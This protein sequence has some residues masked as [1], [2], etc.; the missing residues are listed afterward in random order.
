MPGPLAGLTVIEIASIGPEHFCAMMLADMGTT[1]VRVDRRDQVGRPAHASDVINRDRRSIA[2]DLK[3]PAAVE[4]LLELIDGAE[5][6]VEGFRPGVMEHLVVSREICLARN[7]RLV[8]GRMTGWG[9]EGPL[10]KA[11]GHDIN[12]IALSGALSAIGLEADAAPV[13]PL[14]LANVFGGGAVF[15][16]YGVVCALLE[17]A[18]SGRGQVIGPAMVDGSALVMS[19]FFGMNADMRWPGQGQSALGGTTHYYGGYRCADGEWISIGSI[20]PQFYEL[21]LRTLGI[22]A[23]ATWPQND[24]SRW[25]A[26][27]A[28]LAETFASRTRAE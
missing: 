19:M 23:P 25:P 13:P 11:A 12:Y 22:E 18:R 10:A 1:V 5:S 15:L 28:K 8:F 26:L 24:A 17:A 3:Q 7:P 4:T 14:N 27:K 21:L 20:E 16:A 6:L 9:Q 2:L